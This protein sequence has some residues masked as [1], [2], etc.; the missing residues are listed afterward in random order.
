MSHVKG[1]LRA[2]RDLNERSIIA[3]LRSIGATV[4]QIDQPGD[5]LVRYRGNWHCLEV[6][7]P[8]GKLSEAQVKFHGA[9]EP[10]AIP[11]VTN[12]EEAIEAVL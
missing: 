3:A 7:M 4:Y 5:L 12:E 2:K 1:K 11:V 10:G 8:K 6:K 9:L